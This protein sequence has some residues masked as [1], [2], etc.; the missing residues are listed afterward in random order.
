[1]D[2]LCFISLIGAAT[3]AMAQTG[4]ITGRI[5]TADKSKPIPGANVILMGTNLGASTDPDGFYII[6]NVPPGAY[7]VQVSFV[8]YIRTTVEDVKVIPNYTTTINF[9]SAE[10]R[11]ACAFWN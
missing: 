9:E 11:P 2:V 4:A 1:M 5:Q 7:H 8:G 3:T 10:L 6:T